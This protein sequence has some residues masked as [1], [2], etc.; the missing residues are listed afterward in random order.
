MRFGKQGGTVFMVMFFALFLISFIFAL[1]VVTSG[2][3]KPK[4]QGNTHYIG[5]ES[6]ELYNA[7]FDHA[8]LLHRAITA[9]YVG[10]D[11]ALYA[12][13]SSTTS[14]DSPLIMSPSPCGA[15][16]V[17]VI[18]T[19]T[20]NC[21]PDFRTA[22]EQA[23]RQHVADYGFATLPGSNPSLG[24][25]LSL[26]QTV[27]QK[28]EFSSSTQS[29]YHVTNL[30]VAD[31]D[32][33]FSWEISKPLLTDFSKLSLVPLYDKASELTTSPSFR[34]VFDD[35]ALALPVPLDN[36]A[37]T[38]EGLSIVPFNYPGRSGYDSNLFPHL[39]RSVHRG[40]TI[41][42]LNP[43]LP[44]HSVHDG[45]LIA[46]DAQTM[47]AA[48]YDDQSK[49]TV[50][51]QPVTLH[52]TKQGD[53]VGSGLPF[54]KV[55][56]GFQNLE[57]EMY[58]TKLSSISPSTLIGTCRQPTSGCYTLQQDKDLVNPTTILL[59]YEKGLV[60]VGNPSLRL[61]FSSELFILEERD[62]FAKPDYTDPL[63]EQNGVALIFR[64]GHYTPRI[65]PNIVSL[66]DDEFKLLKQNQF[67]PALIIALL[68]HDY[69]G[70]SSSVS[71]VLDSVTLLYDQ[72]RQ[73]SYPLSLP[74]DA[75]C[76][77]KQISVSNAASAL[78]V[79]LFP[80][81]PACAKQQ[82]LAS[83]EGVFHTYTAAYAKL[84]FLQPQSSTNNFQFGSFSSQ[85]EVSWQLPLDV[86]GL[87]DLHDFVESA[88]SCDV[89]AP[90]FNL[91]V[92]DK[93]ILFADSDV[94]LTT[95][96][97][98]R[99]DFETELSGTTQQYFV[100]SPKDLF[101]Q[102]LVRIRACID[103]TEPVCEFYRYYQSTLPLNALEF[104]IDDFGG[105]EPYVFLTYQDPEHD[106]LH[107]LDTPLVPLHSFISSSPFSS[108]DFVYEKSGLLGTSLTS[109]TKGPFSFPRAEGEHYLHFV[110]EKQGSAVSVV[111]S[112]HDILTG[113]QGP[114]SPTT[115][116]DLSSQKK[117]YFLSYAHLPHLEPVYVFEGGDL[118]LSHF[119]KEDALL[120]PFALDFTPAATHQG[121]TD[122][123]C[124]V[125]GNYAVCSFTLPSTYASLA[126]LYYTSTF[127]SALAPIASLWLANAVVEPRI[128]ALGCSITSCTL[129]GEPLIPYTL[130]T[131]GEAFYVILEKT[132]GVVGVEL[133]GISWKTGKPATSRADYVILP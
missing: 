61:D 77:Q 24:S 1:S 103:S 81:L 19:K 10:V 105:Q 16:V 5:Y 17:P 84:F 35:T 62:V 39:W 91:C 130:Y 30:F 120:I 100:S 29:A 59:P 48:L 51:Y 32:A 58:L 104:H 49:L 121:V 74:V 85:S 11:D 3:S 55:A 21:I 109:F 87:N 94:S 117:L 54:A 111:F 90:N 113:T 79:S 53:I 28:E 15:Y 126:N 65:T 124:T 57:I 20:K 88:L 82:Q 123:S 71:E 26:A 9:T 76:T 68:E 12:L 98:E 99:M 106:F 4:I 64:S 14:A 8:F 6:R 125:L 37:F 128:D 116:A 108:I 46:Y 96:I 80:N 78:L 72:L 83:F 133:E 22:L 115:L 73:Q 13:A 33:T 41:S 89:T 36:I 114:T 86:R 132:T 95:D 127:P 118:V 45:Q 2:F 110:V 129:F 75:A 27:S 119:S 70:T 56:E 92:N 69:L 25:L 131:N 122:L 50:L 67:N 38:P 7:Y 31:N 93:K 52:T 112:A 34:P 101:Y 102:V 23:I 42:L 63:V 66:G 44:I 40:I 18:A 107:V 97:S 47:T 60:E 43:D